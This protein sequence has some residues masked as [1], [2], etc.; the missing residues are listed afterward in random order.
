MGNIRHAC[1]EQHAADTRNTNK[2]AADH[3]P[4]GDKN[5]RNTAP[6]VCI[7]VHPVDA[8]YD[9]LTTGI[10][11]S[12]IGLSEHYFYCFK[13]TPCRDENNTSRHITTMI[14]LKIST[15]MVG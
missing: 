9:V 13:P 15:A 11:F 8:F 1:C 5:N 7:R 2:A 4:P 14:G 6:F 10:H 3:R 12:L